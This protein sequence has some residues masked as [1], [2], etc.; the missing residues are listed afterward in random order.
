MG[1]ALGLGI[2]GSAEMSA[3]GLLSVLGPCHYIAVDVLRLAGFQACVLV[4][5]GYLFF[6]KRE[7]RF[8]GKI[9]QRSELVS[10]DLELQRLELRRIVQR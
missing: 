8:A 5:L 6:P 1:I 7:P 9:L 10:W 4:W 3:A 2:V